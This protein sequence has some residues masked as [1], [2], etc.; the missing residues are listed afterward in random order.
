MFHALSF[1][2]GGKS[3][4][5]IRGSTSAFATVVT[6]CIAHQ[7]PSKPVFMFG[8]M[9]LTITPNKKVII[10]NVEI[11]L[12]QLDGMRKTEGAKILEDTMA[13]IN[14]ITTTLGLLS[15]KVNSYKV[16]KHNMLKTKIEDCSS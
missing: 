13:R 14:Q 4:L 7:I 16:E 11:A 8:S 12:K 9:K 1:L 3:W 15:K 6:V 5:K 10:K 2:S